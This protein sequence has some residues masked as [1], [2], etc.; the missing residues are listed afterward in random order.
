[1][2][3]ELIELLLLVLL[4]DFLGSEFES[5][6]ESEELLDDEESELSCLIGSGLYSS[7]FS[8]GFTSG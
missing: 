1:L 7:T 6:S 5:D 3:S 4:S 2:L 8:S